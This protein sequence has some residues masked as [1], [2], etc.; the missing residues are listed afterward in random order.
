LSCA[1]QP[2][3][4]CASIR[5]RR[6][7][8]RRS[9]WYFAR[10]VANAQP[11][12]CRRRRATTSGA[13][14]ALPPDA[15]YRQNQAARVID[16]FSAILDAR[17]AAAR[18]DTAAAVESWQRAVAAQDRLA[19]HEPP[20]VYYSARESL[21]AALHRA[22]RL[23]EA[24]AVFQDDLARHPR[25]GRSLFGLWQT[26]VALGLREEAAAAKAPDNA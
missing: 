20:P 21:G 17:L 1:L 16:V 24:R 4:R 8:S 26:L 13:A 14:A 11:G 3:G 19:Y 15:T 25:G 7:A 10:S 2:L 9:A 12:A 6:R 23:P 22:G 18:G 5:R